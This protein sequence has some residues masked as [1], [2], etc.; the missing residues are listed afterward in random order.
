MKADTPLQSSE[1]FAKVPV[2]SSIKQWSE[3][4]RPREKLLKLGARRLSD[5]ELL[6]IF[7]NSG[8]EGVTALDLAKSLMS[9]L[10][11]DL[12]RLLEIDNTYLMG[13]VEGSRKKRFPGLGEARAC[14]ILAAIELGRRLR[15]SPPRQRAQ[16]TCSLDAYRILRRHLEDLDH[17]ELWCLYLDASGRVIKEMQISSGGVSH[18]VADLRL[19]MAPAITLYASALILA[20]NHPTGHLQA[21]RN[22]IDLTQRV[23]Q[24]SSVCNIQLNDH[25]ILGRYH[26]SVASEGTTAPPYLSFAD[27]G[28][29]ASL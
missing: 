29:M 15:D 5:A 25:L 6:A 4:D 14:T 12:G 10:D 1:S 11:N 16:I 2:K 23:K 28:L 3:E 9:S 26:S 8:T 27:S 20:H 17:E 21:S 24:I 22:D 7:I 18:A 19:I 13:S